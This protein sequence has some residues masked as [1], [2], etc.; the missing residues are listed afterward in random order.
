MC[1][2]LIKFTI[3]TLILAQIGET[4]ILPILF[5]Q[6][7]LA[8]GKRY[9]SIHSCCRALFITYGQSCYT[10]LHF[11]N[12][13]Q[14][15]HLKCRKYAELSEWNQNHKTKPSLSSGVVKVKTKRL[16]WETTTSTNLSKGLC[17]PRVFTQLT[18]IKRV[19]KSSLAAP[20]GDSDEQTEARRALLTQ[21][22]RG[23][24]ART[25][26]PPFYTEL[27]L[28]ERSP[29]RREQLPG[30]AT[31]TLTI[32]SHIPKSALVPATRCHRLQHDQLLPYS[33]KPRPSREGPWPCLQLLSTHLDFPL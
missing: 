17:C 33:V 5:C 12:A 30:K 7:K 6:L 18:E 11:L 19:F 10:I 22:A 25:P 3:I 31:S 8:I 23:G 9:Q 1:A 15:V 27:L 32:K 28:Y 26:L 14:L 29:P 21:R 20:R 2:G 13:H 4:T 24:G 16:G